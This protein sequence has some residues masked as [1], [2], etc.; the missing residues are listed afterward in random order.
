MIQRQTW[1]WWCIVIITDSPLHPSSESSMSFLRKRSLWRF[2][3]PNQNSTCFFTSPS[4]C[5]TRDRFFFSISLFLLLGSAVPA[6]P[7]P[8]SVSII[9]W[10]RLQHRLV[11]LIRIRFTVIFIYR[12]FALLHLLV[13]NSTHK[14][15]N[16]TYRKS[17][18]IKNVQVHKIILIQ[19][20]IQ[21]N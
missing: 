8:L 19:R 21:D 1:M 9:L 18:E 5:L 17:K 7:A 4:S 6:S 3:S 13:L 12:E 2:T 15:R 10:V 20:I 11:T 14:H 16:K